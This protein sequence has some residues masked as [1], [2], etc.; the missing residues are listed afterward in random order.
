[1]DRAREDLSPDALFVPV[2]RTP[3]LPLSAMDPKAVQIGF[4]SVLRWLSLLRLL[5]ETDF[6]QKLETSGYILL[7]QGRG[8]QVLSF[9]LRVLLVGGLL[10]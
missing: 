2:L 5:L 1:M 3:S 6:C 7:K 10:F 9:S 4:H 8:S